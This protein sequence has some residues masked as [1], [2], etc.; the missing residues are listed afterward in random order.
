MAWLIVA[1]PA[2]PTR[3][4]DGSLEYAVKATYLYKFAPFVQWPTA[5]AAFPAGAFQ[6]CI[7][8]DGEVA[9]LLTRAV[10]GQ[11]VNGHPIEVRMFDNE[12]D[13]RGCSMVYI[14]GTP[15]QVA[16]VLSEVR[17]TPV[18]TVTDQGSAPANT[19]I[20]N[21]V[22][23]DGHVRFDI[24]DDAAVAAGLTI[25]SKLLSLAVHVTGRNQ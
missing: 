12:R 2:R 3:A 23:A 19:G 9:D 14:T 21:F 1:I 8:G 5:T 7:A 6:I 11:Q 16:G 25:S 24:N 10:K 4:Q 20:I 13:G 15:N 22:V 17:G 18:L